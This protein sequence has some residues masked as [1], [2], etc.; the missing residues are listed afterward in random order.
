MFQSENVKPGARV[1][2]RTRGDESTEFPDQDPEIYNGQA[3]VRA[4]QIKLLIY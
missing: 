4:L 2:I 3:W 1:I